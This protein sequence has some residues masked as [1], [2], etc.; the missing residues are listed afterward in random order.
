[1]NICHEADLPF[2]FTWAAATLG[3][4]YTLCGRVTDAT[5]LLSQSMEQS[6]AMGSPHWEGFFHLP[7]GEAYCLTGRLE[8]AHTL[9]QQTLTLARRYQQRGNQA[10]ALRLLGE[11]AA[12]RQP[13]EADQA[14]VYFRQAIG[15]TEELGMRPLQAHCRLGLGTVYAKQG[16]RNRARDELSAAVALYREMAMTF[17]LPQAEAVLT[18]IR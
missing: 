8:E 14:E 4:A 11:V 13:P 7:S 6:T 9:L 17:W 1:M 15:L 12:R 3:E 10:S 2:Y 5:P 16:R 18:Q